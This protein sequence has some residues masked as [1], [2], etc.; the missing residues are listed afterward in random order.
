VAKGKRAGGE[1]RLVFAGTRVSLACSG[2]W[3]GGSHGLEHREDSCLRIDEQLF[4]GR[5]AP[6]F[7]HGGSQ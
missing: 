1:H 5:P 6:L 7:E 3:V 4:R 2:T